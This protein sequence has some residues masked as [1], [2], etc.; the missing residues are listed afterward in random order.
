MWRAHDADLGRAVALKTFTVARPDRLRSLKREF[1]TCRRIVHPNLVGLHEL[2]SEG[3]RAAFSMELV[4]GQ[5]LAKALR[6]APTSPGIAQLTTQW[7]DKV[8]GSTTGTI[9]ISTSIGPRVRRST[10]QP[11]AIDPTRSEEVRRAFL[12]LCAGVGALHAA[13]IVH[14]DLKPSNVLMSRTGRVVVLDFGLA[15]LAGGAR[16]AIA[17]TPGYLAPERA[18]GEAPTPACDLFAIGAMLYFV[19][20]GV[21]P[22]S[23]SLQERLWTLRG[24]WYPAP[25]DVAPGVPADL[26][27][28]AMD[29]LAPTPA[30]RPTLAQ[31]RERLAPEGGQTDVPRLSD[32][33]L[34]RQDE[35]ATLHSQWERTR[36]SDR[37]EGTLVLGESGAGKSALVRR[38]A[39]HTLRPAGA[40]VLR[41]RC[42]PVEH[43]P[44]Q[45]LDAIVD[46]L[47]EVLAQDALAWQDAIWLTDDPDLRR[48]FPALSGMVHAE[49]A[50]GGEVRLR[51]VRRLGRV[52][53][54]VG[55]R[56]DLV[57]VLDDVQWMESD[58]AWALQHIL[59]TPRLRGTVLLMGRPS[60]AQLLG[61]GGALFGR[62]FARLDLRGLPRATMTN[63]LRTMLGSE[64]AATVT[65]LL[66]PGERLP[67]LLLPLAEQAS[68]LA[69]AGAPGTWGDLLDR[70][71]QGLHPDAR[72][73]LE[74]ACLSPVPIPA[75]AV[76][77]LGG[78]HPNLDATAH[79]LV[80]QRLLRLDFHDGE[81]A[82]RPFHDRIREGVAIRVTL[83]EAHHRRLASWHAERGDHE[84]A[85]EAH[86]RDRLG[87]DVGARDAYIR[88]GLHALGKS[89]FGWAVE[90]FE[91]ADSRGAPSGLIG[92]A[93]GE[94]QAGAG[95]HAEAVQTWLRAARDTRGALSRRLRT[96]AAGMAIGRGDLP[97]G[98]RTLERLMQEVGLSLPPGAYPQWRGAP[99]GAD[100]PVIADPAGQ[101]DALWVV[102][103]ALGMFDPLGA[104]PVLK[105]HGEAADTAGDQVHR[106]RNA[107]YSMLHAR[108]TG[109]PHEMVDALEAKIT[110]CSGPTPPNE[111]VAYAH[112]NRGYGL[113]LACHFTDAQAE[114]HASI[115]R[116]GEGGARHWGQRF[117]RTAW[118]CGLVYR[119]PIP[120]LEREV[121]ALV[122]EA[123]ERG[124][125]RSL[126]TTE[127]V[128]GIHID[129][130][131]RDDPTAARGRV[132]SALARWPTALPPEFLYRRLQADVLIG[133]YEGDPEPALRVQRER[134][135]LVQAYCRFRLARWQWDRAFGVAWGRVGA[136]VIG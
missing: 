132:E 95:A 18:A 62:P 3:A 53:A 51:A 28:L 48:V 136:S 46:D 74:L 45:G 13:G 101:L 15:S 84:A 92:E 75:H 25:T 80:D 128:A 16:R 83:P 102:A 99:A 113:Q 11:V 104:L 91:A 134:P 105:A 72:A 55:R 60:A 17:G 70:W 21:E 10:A 8:L 58:T 97:I 109:Q 135:P 90:L 120:E 35:L 67:P 125:L 127:L 88:G 30:Q 59:D 87:D 71:L 36:R 43:V 133:L 2:F 32:A 34:G 82:L 20:T 49:Q 69:S 123:E 94:A 39:T 103:S 77:H 27:A 98:V 61:A 108:A 107:A 22:S 111:L 115:E 47:A 50:D 54:S 1:R 93:W 29:L 63:R 129:L 131:G 86:H 73:L 57:L 65:S 106:A 5:D 19:L 7:P 130:M 9:T 33:W 116:Y 126:I 122:A 78:D 66:G 76:Q 119:A 6:R 114:L 31:V 52:L 96:L 44:F 38:F 14:Q 121:E 68:R 12:E 40:V 26:S 117:A 89:A 118:V 81:A 41:G 24:R 37:A 56:R 124:D 23:G 112:A 64:R 4:D 100:E 79:R 110:A 85:L 42:S